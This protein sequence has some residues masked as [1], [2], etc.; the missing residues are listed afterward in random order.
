MR[1]EHVRR[2]HNI[3]VSIVGV[4]RAG[5]SLI[6]RIEAILQKGE[7]VERLARVPSD[8]REQAPALRQA[9]RPGSPHLVEGQVPSA[10]ERDAVANVLVAGCPEPRR[11]VRRRGAVSLAETRSIV[12]RV[13]ESIRKSEIGAPQA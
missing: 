8:N 7:N 4:T 3:R 2:A 6:T 5:W 13:R 10:A 11:I 1:I 9:L 12:D